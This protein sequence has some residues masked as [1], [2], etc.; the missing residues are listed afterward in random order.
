MTATV[1]V[2]TVGTGKA[3]DLEGS[4][5]APLRKSIAHGKW[6]EVV[7][8]P[9]QMTG[10]MA[11]IIKNEM[12]DRVTISPL[13]QPGLEDNPDACF[14]HFD[15]VLA[16]LLR[17][18][19]ADR[20]GIDITRGTKVMSAALLLASYRRGIPRIRYITGDRDQ[21]GMV[22]K[23][24]EKI[25]EFPTSGIAAAR[26]LD[27]ARALM[28]A[29]QFA[30]CRSML[31]DTAKP[32]TATAWPPGSADDRA[33]AS[34]LARFYSAWDRLDYA[35]ACDEAKTVWEF[36]PSGDW[37]M[38]HPSEDALRWVQ[39]LAQPRDADDLAATAAHLRLLAADLLANGERR[40]R[41]RH[42]EDALIRAYRVLELIGQFR[43]FDQGLD[44]AALPPDHPA[45]VETRRYI[46]RRKDAGFG[47][48]KKGLLTAG[49]LQAARLLRT[50][51]DPF[52]DRLIQLGESP[53][54]AFRGRN[55][56]VLIHG[57]QAAKAKDVEKVF[58]PVGELLLQDQN[59]KNARR[60]L[61]IARFPDFSTR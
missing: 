35:E 39:S 57:F 41:D 20:I 52:G 10:A 49:R 6:D 61:A 11:R 21:Q 38:F 53:N 7:L 5:L 30:A 36:P 46:E 54:F 58:G 55:R 8:L 23:N 31:S 18:R 4:L 12:G 13:P 24:T 28:H 3:D 51:E 33:Y 16:K 40:L 47:I 22:K 44:S 15:G 25:V 43:L 32:G 1:L 60:N 27:R 2:L 42:Y 29:G 50:L 26:R 37:A 48:G 45:V 19:G 59:N 17:T 34:T 14:T 9:S 56:S